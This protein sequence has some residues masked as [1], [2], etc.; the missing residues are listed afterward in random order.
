MTVHAG[1]NDDLNNKEL[2]NKINALAANNKP[3]ATIDEIGGMREARVDLGHNAAPLLT[4]EALMCV[5][6]R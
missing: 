5:L 1:S 3:K 2:G 6:A 4:V